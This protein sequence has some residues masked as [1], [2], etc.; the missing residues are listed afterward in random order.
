MNGAALT[1]KCN[2]LKWSLEKTEK[3]NKSQRNQNQKL[4]SCLL[5][6]KDRR[7]DFEVRRA[8]GIKTTTT[9][10]QAVIFMIIW[11]FDYSKRI[12][13]QPGTEHT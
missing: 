8:W 12:K 13:T 4:T 1:R 9:A 7:F 3:Q 2:N 11:L 6:P 10:A 5:S